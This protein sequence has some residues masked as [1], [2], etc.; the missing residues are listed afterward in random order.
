MVD[1]GIGVEP[2][3]AITIRGWYLLRGRW[4]AGG[5]GEVAGVKA[6]VAVGAAVLV[7][8]AVAVLLVEAVAPAAVLPAAAVVFAAVPAAA[9]LSVAAFVVVSLWSVVVCC[10]AATRTQRLPATSSNVI[11]RL[12][13]E[14]CEMI[15]FLTDPFTRSSSGPLLAHSRVSFKAGSEGPRTSAMRVVR[16]DWANNV[17]E[18]LRSQGGLSAV[19]G[20]K[21]ARNLA[22]KSVARRLCPRKF[23]RFGQSPADR[24]KHKGRDVS[25]GLQRKIRGFAGELITPVELQTGFFQEFRGE[26]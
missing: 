11:N 15:S 10:A 26:S 3:H 4:L 24:A 6:G 12:I 13:K 16:L 17:G 23:Y 20:P 14:A 7:I 22:C 18:R 5:A 1:P 9:V 19:G 25:F 2:N 8:G 21:V